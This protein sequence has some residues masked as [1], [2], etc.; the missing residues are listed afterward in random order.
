MVRSKLEEDTDIAN[1]PCVCYCCTKAVPQPG[2]GTWWMLAQSWVVSW[3]WKTPKVLS[4]LCDPLG[5]GW[6]SLTY[7][8]TV[9]L[10]FGEARVGRRGRVSFVPWNGLASSCRQRGSPNPAGITGQCP[11]HLRPEC[12]FHMV[13]LP[14]KPYISGQCTQGQI[15][16]SDLTGLHWHKHNLSCKGVGIFILFAL[17]L[18]SQ[19]ALSM[20]RIL[21]L[22]SSGLGAVPGTHSGTTNTMFLTYSTF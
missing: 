18:L 14:V 15:P 19:R 20:K 7:F 16:L 22:S 21:P 9:L 1:G 13:V 4:N 5:L 6:W 11:L 17:I 12:I 10:G 8:V 2:W 3:S